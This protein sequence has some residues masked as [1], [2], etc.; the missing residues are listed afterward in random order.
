MKNIQSKNG[1]FCLKYLFMFKNIKLTGRWLC[2]VVILLISSDINLYASDS[3]SSVDVIDSAFDD[4]KRSKKR[5]KKSGKDQKS[6]VAVQDTLDVNAR[7]EVVGGVLT[8]VGAKRVVV[9]SMAS[10]STR[11]DSI[12]SV[13]RLSLDSLDNKIISDST[14]IADSIMQTLSKRELRRFEKVGRVRHNRY[15]WDSIPISRMTAISLVVPGFSQ[16]YNDETWKIPILYGTVGT[17]LYFGLQQNKKYS[18]YKS[19]YDAMLRR[20]ASR[21]ELTPVQTKM[22]QH[23]TYRQILLAGALVSYI[24]FIGDGVV[25]YDGA[26]TSVKKATTLS[27]ICP[28]AGQFYNKSYWKVPIVMGGFATMAY[29]IDFNNRGYQRFDL[30]YDLVVDGDDSTI[31]EF[32][33]H[34]PA[35]FLNK[36]KKSYRRNR[37][38]ALIITAGFYLLNI[39]D[40][41]VDAHL[42]D[43]D[44]SDDLAMNL[45]P[46]FTNIYS[47]NKGN[48]NLFGMNFSISF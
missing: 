18:G 44:I 22:I 37:D 28:G 30:A 39:V 47:H 10:D 40:A 9:D 46:I 5:S 24:Y 25:N 33:G 43:Y 6:E 15:F 26:M 29:I 17:T 1:I 4:G 2:A 19:E 23:N 20:N 14:K 38:L 45:E 42:Q 8:K 34:Y 41:H 32:N 12:A 13:D 35:D 48:Q 27:T 11:I 3:R 36:T 16:L 7:Y 31:D 21:D